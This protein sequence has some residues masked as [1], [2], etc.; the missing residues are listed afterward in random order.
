MSH[1]AD[2][3]NPFAL[4]LVAEAFFR[5]CNR[6]EAAGLEAPETIPLR[7]DVECRYGVLRFHLQV[8]KKGPPAQLAQPTETPDPEPII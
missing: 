3:L 6:M 1:I 7:V 2:E 5:L 4:V 8:V